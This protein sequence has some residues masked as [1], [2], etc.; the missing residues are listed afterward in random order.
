MINGYDTPDARN[1]TAI[2]DCSIAALQGDPV[3]A[4]QTPNFSLMW[5]FESIKTPTGK[6]ISFDI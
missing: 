4:C 3:V 6:S 2:E 1:P 5:R